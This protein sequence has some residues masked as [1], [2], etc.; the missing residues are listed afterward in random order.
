[1]FLDIML[2]INKPLHRKDLPKTP[3][4]DLKSIKPYKTGMWQQFVSCLWRSWRSIIKEP[5]VVRIRVI[6]NIVRILLLK[7]FK[8][9]YP[10]HTQSQLLILPH[11]KNLS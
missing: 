6:Q 2:K 10:V 9:F 11:Q 1:M 7:C 5:A 4:P 3:G 8:F